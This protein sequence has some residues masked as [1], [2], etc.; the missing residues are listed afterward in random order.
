MSI[1]ITGT[2]RNTL[3]ELGKVASVPVGF[4]FAPTV[5]SG[6]D[7]NQ[8]D[9]AVEYAVTILE[10]D[11][12]VIDLS[13]WTGIDFGAGDGNDGTGQSLYPLYQIVAIAI[14]NENGVSDVGMLEVVPDVT[15]GW[16]PIGEHTVATGGALAGQSVL[17]KANLSASA[18][19]IVEGVSSRIA[20][21]SVGGDVAFRILI[22]ARSVAVPSSSSSSS[23]SGA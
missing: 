21:T 1:S 18:F 4:S 16:T 23:S 15:E 9:R 13:S 19:E 5:S 10:D 8:A 17:V 7:E 20:L 12:L 6:T 2:V 22:F 14:S 3:T 11:T